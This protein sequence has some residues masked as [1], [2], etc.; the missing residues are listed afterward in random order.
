MR[1]Y[2]FYLRVV[3]TIFYERAQRAST[4]INKRI[5]T[6]SFDKQTFEDPAPAY[7]NALGHSNFSH[8]LKYIP[9]H[10]KHNDPA[11][12]GNAMSSGSIPALFS[13]NVMT[14]IARSFLHLIDT[15]YPA[16][17]KLHKIFN[18]N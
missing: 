2:E 16:G 13:K 3:E 17:D 14:K 8:K 15:H 9:H 10:M 18:R 12:I 6:L 1:R 4:S 7:Q 5:S 11:G